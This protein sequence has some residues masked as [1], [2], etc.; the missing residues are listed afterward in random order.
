MKSPSSYSVIISYMTLHTISSD[1][2]QSQ[3]GYDSTSKSLCCTQSQVRG[4]SSHKQT[5]TARLLISRLFW[6]WVMEKIS[7]ISSTDGTG[8]IRLEPL[9]DTPRVE[10][11]RTWQNSYNLPNLEVAHTDDAHCLV[12]TRT[13]QSVP[14]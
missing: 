8:S 11:M 6:H 3:F 13:F 14:I 4:V 10:F 1:L 12:I 7:C 2:C 9:V 5:H